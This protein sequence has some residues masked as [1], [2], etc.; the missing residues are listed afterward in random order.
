MRNHEMRE[1]RDKVRSAINQEGSIIGSSLELSAKSI[2][3]WA[4]TDYKYGFKT[5]S[6]FQHNYYMP[7][8]FYILK[9]PLALGNNFS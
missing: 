8:T 1:I 2:L 3:H 6:A 4:S 5:V 9:L 7:S